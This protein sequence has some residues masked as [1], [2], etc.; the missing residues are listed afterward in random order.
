MGLSRE[1]LAIGLSYMRQIEQHKG[2][3][4]EA[5]ANW[6]KTKKRILELRGDEL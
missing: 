1:Q 2:V 6:L 5:L 3:S 4:P